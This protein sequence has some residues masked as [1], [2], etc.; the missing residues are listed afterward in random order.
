M[1]HVLLSPSAIASNSIC[2]LLWHFCDRGKS[3]VAE[4]IVAGPLLFDECALSSSLSGRKHLKYESYHL[5]F[6]ISEVADW[7]WNL[8]TAIWVMMTKTK[9]HGGGNHLFS[10]CHTVCRFTSVGEVCI[11]SC[12]LSHAI[13]EDNIYI[14]PRMDYV[15]KLDY[16]QKRATCCSMVT[17]DLPPKH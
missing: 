11:Y 3:A 7:R 8:G 10:A 5:F 14:S 6:C 4:F 2:W 1:R 12:V 16:F 9:R 15:T 13:D 17:I